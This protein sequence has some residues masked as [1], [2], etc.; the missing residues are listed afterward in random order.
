MAYP[1]GSPRGHLRD[2][3]GQG[4]K[5]EGKKVNWKEDTA[6]T[7]TVGI[8]REKRYPLN[9]PT[10]LQRNH[11]APYQNSLSEYSAVF[12]VYRRKEREGKKPQICQCL[13]PDA[14]IQHLVFNLC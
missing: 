8:Y 3:P 14:P 5:I 11:S 10:P 6:V 7:K 2:K 13:A 9:L 1:V 4:R 12:C